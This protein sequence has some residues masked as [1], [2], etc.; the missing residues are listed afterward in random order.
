MGCQAESREGNNRIINEFGPECK[1]TEH[2]LQGKSRKAMGAPIG[3]SR[4]PTP[5]KEG[6]SGGALALLPPTVIA[7]Y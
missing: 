3:H 7:V 6:T 5:R 2:R 4:A 1:P